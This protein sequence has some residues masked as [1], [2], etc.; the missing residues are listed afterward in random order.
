MDALGD[1]VLL[2]RLEAL[3]RQ[4]GGG[5]KPMRILERL[6]SLDPTNRGNWERWLSALAKA[7]DEVRLRSGVL[8][9][10]AGVERMPIAEE[11][12][13]LSPGLGPK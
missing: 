4:R 11:T 5:G 1:A 12:Q 6:T 9:L 2:S 8:R 3:Y 10:L 7:G 13:I